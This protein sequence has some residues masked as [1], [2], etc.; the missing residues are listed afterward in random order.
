MDTGMESRRERIIR[1]LMDADEPLDVFQIAC[2]LGLSPREAQ[3]LYED[4]RHVA[5]TLKSR[6][7][8]LLMAP[9]ACKTCG[10]VF[11]DLRKPRKPSK[12]PRCRSE[13]ISPPRF[14]VK[15]L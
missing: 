14:T 7:L 3:S 10:Y 4:L 15:T 9:P 2:I 5:R 1:V 13:R 6:G 8:T 11:K 12:C